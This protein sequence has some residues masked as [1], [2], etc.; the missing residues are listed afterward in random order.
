MLY[1]V[2]SRLSIAYFCETLISISKLRLSRKTLVSFLISTLKFC[3]R[4]LILILNNPQK[5]SNSYSRISTLNS[6]ISEK[7]QGIFFLLLLLSTIGVQKIKIFWPSLLQAALQHTDNCACSL[8][9]C[10]HDISLIALTKAKSAQSA[11]LLL[12][13]DNHDTIKY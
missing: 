10:W 12:L 11:I 13:F 5:F 8:I 6:R 1:F 7:T 4:T 3:L 9:C 2:E